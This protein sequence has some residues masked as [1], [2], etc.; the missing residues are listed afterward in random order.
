MAELRV[1]KEVSMIRHDRVVKSSVFSEKVP[2]KRFQRQLS[3][4]KVGMAGSSPFHATIS[5]PSPTGEQRG[6][7]TLQEALRDED[8]VVLWRF[9]MGLEDQC[10]SLSNREIAVA[11]R[12]LASILVNKLKEA[13]VLG[14][15]EEL[16]AAVAMADGKLQILG[17][18][19]SKTL[20]DAKEQLGM[21]PDKLPEVDSIVLSPRASPKAYTILSPPASPKAHSRSAIE[22]PSVTNTTAPS[23]DGEAEDWAEKE[24]F[25]EGEA[26]EEEEAGEEE[27]KE[28]EAGEEAGK[29]EE[30]SGVFDDDD[31][32]DAY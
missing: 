21:D 5:A 7:Q 10:K 13:I 31:D 15:T 16:K 24:G 17:M 32:A 23:N 20:R 19:G 18:G 9:Y 2:R 26:A 12:K 22:S 3:H 4:S 27:S 28:E 6:K 11:G 29:E 14:H 25:E 30:A 8:V 1:S